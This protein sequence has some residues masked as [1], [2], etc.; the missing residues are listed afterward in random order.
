MFGD[1][2]TGGGGG[3]MSLTKV[4]DD[5]AEEVPSPPSPRWGDVVVDGD[6]AV[7]FELE[8]AIGIGAGAGAGAG[9]GTVPSFPSSSQVSG[10]PSELESES[11]SKFTSCRFSMGIWGSPDG[12]VIVSIALLPLE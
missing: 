8:A 10:S 3:G 7:A 4:A 11:S 1:V 2:L 6:V 12:V 9:A 5:A